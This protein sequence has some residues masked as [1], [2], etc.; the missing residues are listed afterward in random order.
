MVFTSGNRAE[1]GLT[2]VRGPEE[3]EALLWETQGIQEGENNRSS[4]KEV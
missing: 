4:N 3:E 1:I 2:V